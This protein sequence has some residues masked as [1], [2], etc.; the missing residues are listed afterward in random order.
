MRPFSTRSVVLAAFAAAGVVCTAP[1]LADEYQDTIALF[2]KADESRDFFRN[3][4]GYAVFPL[5]GKGGVGIGGAFGKGRVYERGNYIGDTTMTQLSVGLQLGGE[6]YSQIIF[7]SDPVALKRFTNGEFA[8]GAEAS[9]VAITAGANARAGTTGV[10]AGASIE[11]D[12]S[13][14]LGQ[15]QNGMAVFTVSRGGLMYQAAL[16]GQKFSYDKRR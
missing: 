16:N 6:G 10:T 15:Y 8:F 14:N 11:K 13:R 4:H 3:S 1:A 2:K 5:V 7:F 12:K 9:A